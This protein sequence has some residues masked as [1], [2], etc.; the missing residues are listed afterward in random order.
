[1]CSSKRRCAD[2]VFWLGI[3][4]LR[5]NREEDDDEAGFV[6]NGGYFGEWFLNVVECVL[7]SSFH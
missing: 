7:L 1:M 6:Y 4:G 3:E 2:E 5:L